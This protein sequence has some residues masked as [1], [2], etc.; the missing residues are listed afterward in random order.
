MTSFSAFRGGECGR[1]L[2]QEGKLPLN[3]IGALRKDP[4]EL[5]DTFPHVKT[6]G[7]DSC[8]ETV[9]AL[10]RHGVL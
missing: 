10:T 1:Y 4:R 9:C 5:S 6:H 7:K 8:L 2:G 3:G